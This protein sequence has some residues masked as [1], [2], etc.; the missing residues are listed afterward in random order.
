[1]WVRM[2]CWQG[3]RSGGGRDWIA[4]YTKEEGEKGGGPISKDNG[5]STLL[6]LP[7]NDEIL[8]STTLVF[9]FLTIGC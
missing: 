4:R 5:Q 8:L 1:M 3:R 7:G 2:V 6:P 9:T